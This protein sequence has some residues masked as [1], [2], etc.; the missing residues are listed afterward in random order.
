MDG[1]DY[2]SPQSASGTDMLTSRASAISSIMGSRFT[3]KTWVDMICGAHSMVYELDPVVFHKFV[4]EGSD[5]PEGISHGRK[6]T[7]ASKLAREPTSIL[8]VQLWEKIE[9]LKIIFEIAG[10]DR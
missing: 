5:F 4:P 2:A 7:I 8:E 6:A 3:A 10:I 1:L 9:T